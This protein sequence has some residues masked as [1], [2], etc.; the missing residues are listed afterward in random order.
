MRSAD[1]HSPRAV[2]AQEGDTSDPGGDDSD[3][4]PA[5]GSA[6]ADPDPDIAEKKMSAIEARLE[7]GARRVAE[8]IAHDKR[9]FDWL[10]EP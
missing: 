10:I 1:Y 2:G 5:A 8:L 7:A 9:P 4:A 3:E 6:G